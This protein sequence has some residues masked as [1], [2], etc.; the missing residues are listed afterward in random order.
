MKIATVTL[1]RKDSKRLPGKNKR[2]LAGLPLYLYAVDTALEL[3]WPYHVFTNYDAITLPVGVDEHFYEGDGLTMDRLLDID[4]DVFVMLPATSP[5]RDAADIKR[6]VEKFV[7]SGAKI[8]VPVVRCRPGT[9]YDESR[10][11]INV[12]PYGPLGERATKREV[13]R[14]CG[15]VYAFRRE[16]LN[17][18]C[19]L[20]CSHSDRMFYVDPVGIDINTEDDWKEAERWLEKH[21]S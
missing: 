3:G 6:A 17:K 7:A 5:I 4:A 9:Y 18:D 15:T 2:R 21:T 20:S 1:M 12:D 8:M 10:V 13:F 14:E 19:F 16:Q 11:Q